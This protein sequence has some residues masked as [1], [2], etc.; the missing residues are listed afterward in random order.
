MKSDLPLL[1]VFGREGC[2][3]C[4]EMWEA[5]EELRADAN[6]R[7][8]WVDVDDDPDLARRYGDKVPVLAAGEREICH[9]FLEMPAL[10]AFLA[11][12]R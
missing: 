11:E 7:L 2:H 3:L 5:L 1:T 6:F 10:N 12:I 4:W 9:Y 8:S